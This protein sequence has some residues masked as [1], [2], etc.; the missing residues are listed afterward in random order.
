METRGAGGRAR[1]GCEGEDEAR[2]RAA[3]VLF[4]SHSPP[5]FFFKFLPLL[6]P[7]CDTFSLN[8]LAQP[9]RLPSRRRLRAVRVPVGPKARARLAFVFRVGVFL[10]VIYSRDLVTRMSACLSGGSDG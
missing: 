2:A 4:A 7:L 3:V 6:T 10:I 5:Y 8:R 9:P 1:T